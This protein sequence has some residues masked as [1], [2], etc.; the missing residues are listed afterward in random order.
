MTDRTDGCLHLDSG[1]GAY[2]RS[3]GKDGG[4]RGLTAAAIYRRPHNADASASHP[5]GGPSFPTP[6]SKATSAIG[7]S[8]CAV[9]HSQIGHLSQALRA[10][11][12]NSSSLRCSLSWQMT[13]PRRTEAGRTAD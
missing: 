2:V 5:P 6:D 8:V 3:S 7:I 11:T 1:R 13:L 4:G 10:V 9:G 12:T